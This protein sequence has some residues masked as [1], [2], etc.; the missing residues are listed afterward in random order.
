MYV[1]DDYPELFLPDKL[2]Q[3]VPFESA[4]LVMRWL[5]YLLASS[6]MREMLSSMA[7]GTSG[8]M[9]NITKGELLGLSIA[10][11][12]VPE[13]QQ[14]AKILSTTDRK[15]DHLT[16]QKSQTQQL[17]KGLMQKLLTGQIWVKP[18]PQDH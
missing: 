15:L 5:S 12:P 2:W 14:T 17:K 8:S 9:K 16:T 10:L 6:E 13:Q 11:P 1:D 3:T 18:E 7:T 4:P